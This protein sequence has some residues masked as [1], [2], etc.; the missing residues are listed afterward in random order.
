MAANKFFI[1]AFI[2]VSLFFL[3]SLG[4][5]TG[6]PQL[7][8]HLYAGDSAVEGISRRQTGEVIQCK[9]VKMD[10]MVCMPYADLQCNFQVYVLGCAK[11]KV[12]AFKDA[13]ACNYGEPNPLPSPE[14]SA[15]PSG[16]PSPLPQEN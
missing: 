6:A 4:C 3:P 12:Q 1:L 2:I 15:A 14:P 5:K 7:K 8:T 13:A 9:D 16:E 10:D 11:W